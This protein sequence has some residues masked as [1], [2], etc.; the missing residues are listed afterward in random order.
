MDQSFGFPFD[1][2]DEILVRGTVTAVVGNGPTA[3]VTVTVDAP[4]NLGDIPNVAF[5]IGASQVHG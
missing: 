5:T 2:G 4:G 1:V 3:Q